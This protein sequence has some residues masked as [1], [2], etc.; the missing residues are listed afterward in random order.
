MNL[1]AASYLRIQLLLSSRANKFTASVCAQPGRA[2]IMSSRSVS[3]WELFNVSSEG[4]AAADAGFSELSYV[5]LLQLEREIMMNW[6]NSIN[7]PQFDILR[8]PAWRGLVLALYITTILVGIIGNGIVFLVVVKN[9]NMQT[10]TNIFIANLALSDIGLCVFSLPVQLHYQ[11]TDKWIFGLPMCKVIFAAFAVPMYVSTLTILL[12]AF[13]RY[14]LILYPLKERMSVRMA[15]LLILLIVIVSILLSVPVMCF[16][17]LEEVDHADLGIHRTYCIERWPDSRGRKAY[18]TITFLLQFCLPLLMTA[19]LYYRIYC[20]LRR[21]PNQLRLNQS[22]ERKHKTNKILVA[23]VTLFM[24]CWLPWN[25][26]TLIT[27]IDHNIVKGPHFKFVDL[28][29]KV[30]AMGSA[31]VNPFLYCWLNDN[32][33]R[34]IDN[35]AIKMHL[36][37]EPSRSSRRSRDHPPTYQVNGALDGDGVTNGLM[38]QMTSDPITSTCQTMV[39][40]STDP[41]QC[42][43]RVNGL[44]SP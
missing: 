38:S 21:R 35:I 7:D 19:L 42:P 37:R 15:M 9:K 16:T 2:G 3:T 27:E 25:L 11:M 4:G 44:L 32:F 8:K 43:N 6:S 34:E 39:T 23:I 29:L 36:Y 18:S 17:R 33:R 24:I 12:I 26:F 40:T 20:R 30:F 41:N 1:T 28:L 22:Q 5:E 13:D 14:W 10:V 31:C